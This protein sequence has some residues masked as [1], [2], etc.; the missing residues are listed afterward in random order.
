M[1]YL[2]FITSLEESNEGYLRAARECCAI[3]FYDLGGSDADF[4]PIANLLASGT[5]E[6]DVMKGLANHTIAEPRNIQTYIDP[7]IDPAMARLNN[8]NWQFSYLNRYN[9]GWDQFYTDNFLLGPLINN[10]FDYFDQWVMHS[11]MGLESFN[12]SAFLYNQS[13]NIYEQIRR[14]LPGYNIPIDRSDLTYINDL[15]SDPEVRRGQ[16]RE[17]FGRYLH[18]LPSVDEYNA[19]IGASK[20]L[21]RT[22]ILGGTEFLEANNVSLI[23]GESN[24]VSF[25]QK[26]IKRKTHQGASSTVL[27]MLLGLYR[28]QNLY[29]ACLHLNETPVYMA[30]HIGELTFRYGVTGSKNSKT[31][32][33]FHEVNTEDYIRYLFFTYYA[34]I[35][36]YQYGNPYLPGTPNIEI[37][38]SYVN[39]NADSWTGKQ[40]IVSKL[41][42]LFLERHPTDTE[43]AS[44]LGIA[45]ND[46]PD[47]G[48]FNG[49]GPLLTSIQNSIE[50]RSLQITLAYR[51]ILDR[52]PSQSEVDHWIN[53]AYDIKRLRAGIM[54][55]PKTVEH[56]NG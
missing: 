9:N 21:L 53:K 7:R 24:I 23:S 36:P 46:I 8:G 48:I 14:V 34:T 1:S 54:S 52:E 5:S 31:S 11:I 38:L 56:Y 15:M 47:A 4:Q 43:M 26:L 35:I 42:I 28:T 50:A 39:P 44:G 19:G 55:D 37:R 18:R 2:D 13:N 27:S 32:V 49:L 30:A 6:Y 20:K 40:L 12:K 3:V 33:E 25:F 45:N 17:I 29:T 41:Y 10:L 51:E 16:V 22:T